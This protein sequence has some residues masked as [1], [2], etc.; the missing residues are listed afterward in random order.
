MIKWSKTI[1][2]RKD[3][4]TVSTPAL[5][6]S[7]L[8]PVNALKVM[9]SENNNPLFI[10]PRSKSLVPL[11]DL[12]AKKHVKDVCRQFGLSNSLTFPDFKR[13]G[14]SWAFENGVQLEHIIKHG[15]WKSE[16]G[17]ICHLLPL[18]IHLLSFI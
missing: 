9:M 1:K 13:G 5:G 14:A 15:T 2:N 18:C 4:A 10:I 16:Y 3:I 8:C 12:V 11:T 6:D 7:L 17:Y